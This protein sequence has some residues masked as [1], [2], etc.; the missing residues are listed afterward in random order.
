MTATKTKTELGENVSYSVDG[1]TLTIT[2]DL[3]HR[4][5]LSASGKTFR[6]AS[7]E[8]NKLIEGTEVIVGFNAYVY[9]GPKKP[10]S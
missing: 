8:G 2:V 6:V 10:R 7:T 3:K 9:A 4:G 1:D 5:D